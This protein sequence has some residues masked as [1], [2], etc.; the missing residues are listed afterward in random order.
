MTGFTLPVLDE[1][2]SGEGYVDQISEFDTPFAPYDTPTR[3][4][5]HRSTFFFLL[6]VWIID[7]HKR[8]C[9]QC[10]QSFVKRS[11]LPLMSTNN[12]GGCVGFNH[13]FFGINGRGN[14]KRVNSGNLPSLF[15]SFPT[16]FHWRSLRSGDIGV[17]GKN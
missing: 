7:F 5:L 2:K 11:E 3:Y 14:Q 8:R 12:L 6:L 9:F 15:Q 1:N 4:H 16:F 13:S 17:P 10:T